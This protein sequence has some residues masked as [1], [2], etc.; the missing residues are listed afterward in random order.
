[1]VDQLW[2]IRHSCGPLIAVANHNGHEMRQELVALSVLDEV[3]RLREEDPYTGEW[4]EVAPSSMVAERSRFEVDLNRPRETA[5]YMTPE[6]A[7]G[8]ELWNRTPPQAVIDTLLSDYDAY[9]EA[10]ESL[11]RE[12][13]RQHGAFVVLDLHSYNHRRDGPTGPQADPAGNPE[14]NIGTG[15]MDRERWGSLVDRFIEDLRAFDFLGRHL[16]VRENIKFVGRQFPRWVHTRFPE[17]GCAIAVE[18]KKFFMDEW[19]GELY[20]EQHRAIQE[21]LASTLPGLMHELDRYG[22][23]R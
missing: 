7:W 16:D 22:V 4:A 10:L 21:A 19:T 13:Q 6:D 8:L 5:I 11:C 17:T 1:M 20:F 15:T 14:V 2:R 23:Q 18:I 9:Y 12:K 3:T